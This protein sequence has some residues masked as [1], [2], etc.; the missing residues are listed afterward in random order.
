MSGNVDFSDSELMFP[1]PPQPVFADNRSVL[2][3]KPNR[4]VEYLF[5]SSG[6]D[7]KA[8]IDQG[9]R[10]EDIKQLAQLIG[11]PV[12]DVAGLPFVIQ[13]MREEPQ[14]Q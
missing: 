5:N 11:S 7:F 4:L 3:H 2:R 10:E 14:S 13:S 1:H 12:E 9:F 8:I 6:L